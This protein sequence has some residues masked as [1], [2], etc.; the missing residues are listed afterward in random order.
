[1]AKDEKQ[2]F[3]I[4]ASSSDRRVIDLTMASLLKTVTASGA[5]A[6]GPIL[7]KNTVRDG[8]TFHSRK[9][10]VVDPTPVTAD[11]LGELNLSQ[12]VNIRILK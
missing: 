1:M 4:A 12:D 8:I 7:L 9:L 10:T 6:V 11:A 5:S 2:R 3:T